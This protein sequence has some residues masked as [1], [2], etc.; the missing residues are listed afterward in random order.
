MRRF[1]PDA[2]VVQRLKGLTVERLEA[3]PGEPSLSDRIFIAAEHSSQ[4][5]CAHGVLDRQP[6][7]P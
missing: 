6:L 4:L 7:T 1:A 3:S 5:R 2:G